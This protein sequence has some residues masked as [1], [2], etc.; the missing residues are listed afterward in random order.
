LTGFSNRRYV[1][2][3]DEQGQTALHLA[4]LE[5]QKDVIEALLSGGADVDV[6]AKNEWGRTP[7]H[8]PVERTCLRPF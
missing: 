8:L 7:L 1:S 2:A 5:G 3:K 4:A 6:R